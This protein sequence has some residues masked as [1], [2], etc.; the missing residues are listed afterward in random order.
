MMLPPSSHAALTFDLRKERKAKGSYIKQKNGNVSAPGALG[1]MSSVKLC[2]DR[3]PLVITLHSVLPNV[4]F[5]IP[6]FYLG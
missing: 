3:C 6:V 4:V 2:S 1:F 5:T